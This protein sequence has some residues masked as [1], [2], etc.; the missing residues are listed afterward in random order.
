MAKADAAVV[1]DAGPLIHLDELHCVDVLGDFDQILI[2][3]IV[4]TEV[5]KHRQQLELQTIPHATIEDPSHE[6]T[7]RL[8][9]LADSLLLDAGERAALALMEQRPASMLLC[10][11]AAARL[12]A[13]SLGFMVHGTI[14]VIV[15]AVRIGRRAPGD[16]LQILE[17]IPSQST[18][19]LSSTLLNQVIAQVKHDISH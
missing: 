7:A 17:S 9:A 3:R 6:P 13:E 19:H 18:L 10:D 2:P 11:D 14:G 5:K 15:R 8:L 16:V 1:S 12:A 4:W